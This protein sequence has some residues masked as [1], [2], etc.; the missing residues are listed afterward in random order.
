MP[1]WIGNL[2]NFQLTKTNGVMACFIAQAIILF[3]WACP[4][5]AN[6]G[7]WLAFLSI[8]II[9]SFLFIFLQTNKAMRKYILLIILL[10][11]FPRINAS[12]DSLN[13]YLDENKTILNYVSESELKNIQYL[14][15]SGFIGISDLD[16]IYSKMCGFRKNN[17]NSGF[18][19][20]GSLK[21]LDLSEANIMSYYIP[22]TTFCRP[23]DEIGTT[24]EELYLPFCRFGTENFHGDF[25]YSRELKKVV[26]QEGTEACADLFSY[27]DSLESIEIPNSI[28]LINYSFT[29]KH[30][31]RY[32]VK[33]SH[34]LFSTIDGALVSKDHKE[35]IRVPWGLYKYRV[36]S[37]ITTISWS[38]FSRNPNIEEI[39]FGENVS[40]INDQMVNCSNL[41]K[42]IITSSNVPTLDD[43]AFGYNPGV[44]CKMI[45]NGK[46]YVP[47]GTAS[48]YS[49]AP[50]WCHIPNIIEYEDYELQNIIDEDVE[51]VGNFDFKVDNIYYKIT[52]FPDLTVGV[53]SGQRGYE[54]H[55]NIPSKVVYNNREFTVTSIIRMSGD[56]LKSVN[57]PETVTSI[58]S[59]ANSG[60]ESIDIPNNVTSINSF[61]NCKKLEYVRISDNVNRLKENLFKG[62]QKLKKIDWT[63]KGDEAI[64]EGH[65]FMECNSL[66]SFTIP[67][68]VSRTGTTKSTLDQKC[69]FIS[70]A[71]LD[72]IILQD[73]TNA[74]GLGKEYLSNPSV[75]VTE[76][77][78]CPI[79]YL[80]LG[81][82][83]N[84]SSYY[85]QPKFNLNNLI[86]GDLVKSLNQ[87]PVLTS[88]NNLVSF[89]IGKSLLT[90]IPSFTRITSIETI[91][92]RS[93]TPPVAQGFSNH[94]YMNATLYV[95]I[96]SKEIYQSTDIWKNFWNV[97]EFDCTDGL[98]TV[99][100]DDDNTVIGYYT[101]N[102]YSISRPMPGINI[103]K[104][105]N[106]KTSKVIIK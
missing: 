64:I 31:K 103:I 15:I 100:A 105:K 80:Y 101:I 78:L 1:F 30:M 16:L 93:V 71:L 70:C 61:L 7:I 73:T 95:P 43:N 52:S 89:T 99:I 84:N 86:I 13:I 76:F 27:C 3:L 59:F 98:N 8:S 96:G 51:E 21:V 17:T 106:G 69:A 39:C 14:K 41:L 58:G 94:T 37:S 72:T 66:T 54:G 75:T 12:I 6:L 29:G 88:E 25:H 85:S 5:A 35:L 18:V 79:K 83:I 60:L 10:S 82:E 4:K 102:G 48:L 68:I 23:W 11:F 49:V 9:I 74:I 92:A 26:L 32:I 81:R 50:G 62:C 24:L 45:T 44:N 65:A 56:R 57:I 53:T 34:P 20:V 42:I 47:K 77:Y 91:F 55:I 63:P 28:G 19:P 46:L 97:E 36:P 104:Y 67:A 33:P 40:E 2:G 87:W 38:A 22:E 90:S